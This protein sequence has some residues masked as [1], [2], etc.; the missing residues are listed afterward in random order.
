MSSPGP[1][2]RRSPRTALLTGATGFIGSSLAVELLQQDR[3]RIFCV[4]RPNG[5]VRERLESAV[6]AA[7]EAAGVLDQV[8]DRLDRLVPVDG[9]I[10]A[11]G[12]GLTDD[13]R[14][15]LRSEHVDE[16]WHSAA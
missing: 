15:M 1:S 3:E 10:M 8:R 5:D 12:L 14:A 9:D 2:P 6:T 4:V 13:G 16:C 7:A 11:E